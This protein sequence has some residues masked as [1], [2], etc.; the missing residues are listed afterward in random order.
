MPNDSPFD[1]KVLLKQSWQL[2][3]GAKWAIWAPLVVLVL[4]GFGISLLST[5]IFSLFGLSI[6][7]G[8]TTGYTFAYVIIAF[9]IEIITLFVTAPLI[10][11]AQMVALK[12]VRD[13]TIDYMMGF[14]YWS[15]WIH[16]GLTLIIVSLGF[17]LI[18]LIFGILIS[19]SYRIGFWLVLILQILAL[20]TFIVYYAFFIFAVLFVADKKAS[21]IDALIHCYQMVRPHWLHVSTVIFSLAVGLTIVLLPYFLLSTAGYLLL[22]LLGALI[23]IGL[24][25]WVIPWFHLIVFNISYNT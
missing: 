13:E 2:T 19:L 9:I 14:K 5:L 21:P 7:G 23:S 12:R 6:H 22:S 16:L 11:G 4:I 1:I 20:I 3:T 25:I 18:N 8:F 24:A 17:G 15:L 10:A